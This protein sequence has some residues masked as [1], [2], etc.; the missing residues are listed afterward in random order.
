MP[1][2]L[3]KIGKAPPPLPHFPSVLQAFIFRAAEFVSF[4]KIARILKTTRENVAQAAEQL[5]ITRE[6]TTNIWTSKGYITIIKSMWHILPYAQLLELLEISEEELATLLRQEDF[7][8]I[9]LSDKP[10]CPPVLWQEPTDAQI[11]AAKQAASS[12]KGLE[13]EGK[14]PFDFEYVMPD[15]RFEGK[16][17][18]ETRMIY[19]FSGLYQKAFDVDSEEY[20]SDR[21]LESYKR[22]GINAVWT[23]GVLSQLAEYPFDKTLSRGYESR[24]M[25]LRA[26]TERCA[27][28]GIKVFLYLNEPRSI[29]KS[30]YDQ[31]PQLGGHIAA[32]DKICLCTS[33]KNVQEYLTDAVES[34]CRAAPLLG[35]FFTITRSE[36]P[37]NCY[38]HSTPQTC[39]CPRCK[40]KSVGEVIGQVVSCIRNGADRVSRDIKVIAW[41]WAWKEFN[42]D[43]INHLPDRVVLQS[44]SELFVPYEIGGIKG[45]VVD[46]SMGIIGPGQRAIEE[47]SAAR[48]RGLETGAKIQVNT[49]WEGSTVPALPLFGLIEEHLQRLQEQGVSHLMLSW[50]LG[51]YPSQNLIHAAKYYTENAVVCTDDDTNAEAYA[52]F[53]RAFREF[54]FDM[55]VLYYG[56]QNGGPSNLLFEKPTGYRATMTCFAYDDLEKWRSIYPVDIFEQQLE[57]LCGLWRQGLELLKDDTGSET[58]IMAEAAYCLYQS[59]LDQVRFY[60]ARSSGDRTR[61]KEC[62]EAEL[63]TAKRMLALMNKNAA[64]GFEAANHYYFSKGMIKEKILNCSHLINSL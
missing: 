25:R 64:I 14:R 55:R 37:T 52:L 36:N 40:Q 31:K 62:A 5:G 24:Q 15:I 57:K 39:S 6:E 63:A 54:P 28:Y 33:R 1:F 4:D 38:S 8:D 50:T 51:G 29:S 47:W 41:S 61:M 26:F 48:R 42:I 34:V 7:L 10:D 59:S 18:F 12:L 22:L 44:Q 30:L 2:S 11:A 9:K 20:C 58:E 27:K 53:C 3:P 46:Y 49:T 17:L 16:A 35:G 13:A 19:L 23:Q 32:D 45:S 60:R 21:M 56:P 43:I